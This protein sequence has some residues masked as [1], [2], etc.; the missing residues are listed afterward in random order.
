M[1][2]ILTHPRLYRHLHDDDAPDRETFSPPQAPGLLSY[3]LVIDEGEPIGVLIVSHH[4]RYLWEL[5]MAFLPLAWGERAERAGREF[6]E[7]VWSK[8]KCVRLFGNIVRSNRLSLRFAKQAGMMEF[9]VQPRC[10]MKHG[11]LQDIVMVAIQRPGA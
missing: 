11:R 10:F 1:K 6:I 8:T 3:V 5:H 9:A 2:L 7:W 4:S